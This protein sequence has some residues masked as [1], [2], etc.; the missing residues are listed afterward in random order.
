MNTPHIPIIIAKICITGK[1]CFSK[2]ASTITK[3]GDERADVARHGP[4]GPR[5][6]AF[7]IKTT[8]N[9]STKLEISPKMKYFFEKTSVPFDHRI[10]PIIKMITFWPP[11]ELKVIRVGLKPI[12]SEVKCFVKIALI[13]ILI[14]TRNPVMIGIHIGMTFC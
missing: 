9:P 7:W 13:A 5:L 12:R 11:R 8:P 3:S 4:A 6:I 14:G 10:T 1:P 2:M